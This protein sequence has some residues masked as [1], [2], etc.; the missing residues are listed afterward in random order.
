[1]REKKRKGAGV[2]RQKKPLRCY[3]ERSM[4]SFAPQAKLL[5]L[6]PSRTT[7][8]PRADR[9]RRHPMLYTAC[10]RRSPIIAAV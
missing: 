9:D 7:P 3:P 2:R 8:H 10:Q 5:P 1:V 4:T 6:M